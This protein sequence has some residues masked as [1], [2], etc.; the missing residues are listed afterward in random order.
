M[1]RSG[2]MSA[3]RGAQ[4]SRERSGSQKRTRRKDEGGDEGEVKNKV[5]GKSLPL[6][7][8][9]SLQNVIAG[10]YNALPA[11]LRDSLPIGQDQS[12][13]STAAEDGPPKDRR[14]EA[15]WQ[16]VCF[17][18][19]IPGE[20]EEQGLVVLADGSMRKY[21]SLKGINVLLFDD[22]DRD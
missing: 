15:S 12:D 11:V 9:P 5:V 17:I 2:R 3:L 16:D 7:P 6:T 18:H 14:G 22:T 4:G 21:I 1:S 20:D 19:S 8:T 10:F 13:A